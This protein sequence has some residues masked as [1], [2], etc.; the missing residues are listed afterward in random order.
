MIH[1]IVQFVVDGGLNLF[2]RP[3][4]VN[5]VCQVVVLANVV[6][7]WDFLYVPERNGWDDVGAVSS[8]VLFVA[9]VIILFVNSGLKSLTVM[10]NFLKRSA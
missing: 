4:G 10:E 3:L 9:S 6:S 8:F 5:W 7:N 2:V 1:V